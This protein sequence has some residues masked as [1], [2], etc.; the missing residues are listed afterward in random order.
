MSSSSSLPPTKHFAAVGWQV[1]SCIIH[2]LGVSAMSF[3]LSRRLMREHFTWHGLKRIA[4]PR[5]LV[6]LT[7]VDSWAFLFTAGVLIQGAGLRLNVTVCSLAIFNC[8]AFYASSKILIYWFLIEKIRVVWSPIP[9]ASRLKSPVYI[10]C[11][12]DGYCV[13]G[14]KRPAS[15]L[16][17][18]Y[19]LSINILFTSL[20]LW[21]LYRATFRS[22]RV[23][24]V[25]VRTL[26][27]AAVALTTSCVNILVLTLMKGK[28]LG[29]V[30]LDSCGTDVIINA[31]VL[32]WVTS[33]RNESG[34]E[35]A[36]PQEIPTH[37][38]NSRQSGIQ[39]S[40]L[41]GSLSRMPF[42]H[43]RR[44]RDKQ[45][46][47]STDVK[48]APSE[49]IVLPP[50]E[51]EKDVEMAAVAKEGESMEVQEPDRKPQPESGGLL[52]RT[53]ATLFGR[54]NRSMPQDIEIVVTRH[55]DVLHEGI[56]NDCH[57]NRMSAAED[58]T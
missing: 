15:V 58:A 3:L 16:L 4:L 56:R 23:R 40:I 24:Q 55:C 27:A 10:V 54:T 35:A 57:M 11:A 1:T 36:P 2:L 43:T 13:I 5:L 47:H 9:N 7:L 19:D 49:V 44:G 8:I 18:S 22:A 38:S 28:Q 29:W 33:K 20:F 39:P 37:V 25:A 50:V 51:V 42:V 26:W 14:L 53:V 48:A 46:V 41:S 32:F 45:L 31:I 17:L 6:I 12:I 34:S 52:S 21:P 30:C